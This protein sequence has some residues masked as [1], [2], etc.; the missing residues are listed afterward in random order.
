MLATYVVIAGVAAA[1]SSLASAI[2]IAGGLVR[3]LFVEGAG[4]VRATEELRMFRLSKPRLVSRHH[5]STSKTPRHPPPFQ[6]IKPT[7]HSRLASESL[8][9][10]NKATFNSYRCFQLQIVVVLSNKTFYELPHPTNRINIL[11]HVPPPS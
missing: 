3:G 10:R 1:S 2:V 11:K 8:V 6:I 7:Q 4:R 5:S 9:L